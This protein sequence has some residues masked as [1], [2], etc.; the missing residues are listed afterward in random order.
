MTIGAFDP[1][2]PTNASQAIQGDDE[3]RA[4]KEG[5]QQTFIGMTNGT[6]GTDDVQQATGP[7]VD[8]GLSAA[9]TALQPGANNSQLN[10]DSQ[11]QSGTEVS[12]TV[13]TAVSD[14]NLSSA[15]HAGLFAGKEDSA[16]KGQANGY[17]ALDQS[18]IVPL[19]QLP[20]QTSSGIYTGEVDGVADS[21]PAGWTATYDAVNSQWTVTTTLSQLNINNTRIV[22]T[23]WGSLL[24]FP[25]AGPAVFDVQS[26]QNDETFSV[27]AYG[28]QD[29]QNPLAFPFF[30]MLDYN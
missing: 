24:A 4:I 21:L 18:G 14:H 25:S 15:A 30:F 2:V 7:E 11:Y 27:R 19:S 28:I 22:C 6:P 13:N 8:A 17:A 12:T 3:I 16:N 5:V 10:N 20:A 23:G 29:P 1:L 26:F 9:G